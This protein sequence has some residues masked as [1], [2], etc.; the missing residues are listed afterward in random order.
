VALALALGGP[1]RFALPFVALSLGLLLVIAVG[2]AVGLVLHALSRNRRLHDRAIFLGIGLGVLLSLVPL[3]LLSRGGS[4]A[5]RLLG[6]LLQHDVFL[7]SPFAWSARAAVHA[8]RGEGLAFVAL[9]GAVTLALAATVGV[10]TLVAQRLY[11]GELVSGE[12]GAS[13]L[14]PARMRLPGVIGALVEKYSRLTLAIS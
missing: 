6:A 8:S 12:A 14:G 1:Q 2:Q 3:L 5:R 4:S 13:G 9:C 11:R 7:V 10:S